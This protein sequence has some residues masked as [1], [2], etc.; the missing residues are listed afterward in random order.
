MKEAACTATPA[1]LRTLF[2]HILTFCQ[3]KDPVSLWGRIWR[4]MSEDLPYASSVSLNI[5]NLH[6]HDSQLEDYVLYELEGCLNHCSRSLTDFGLRLPPKDLMAVLRNRL[7]IEEKSYNRELLAK[8]KDTLLRK[9]NDK[10]R[11][12]FDLIINASTNNRQELIFVY[13]HGGTGKT[14]LWKT[15]T[16]TLRADRKIVLTVA[17]SGVASL[18]LPAGR[19]SHS[20]FKTLR[21]I[22]SKLDALFGGKTVMLGGDFRQTLPVKGGASRNEIVASSIAKSY[23]W[24]HFT[25]HILTENM[26]LTDENMDEMQKE[27]VSTFA[28]WLLDIGDGSIGIPDEYDPENTS[29]VEIPNIY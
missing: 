18:L 4:S 1:E 23:L 20:R 6:I 10:Q 22:L 12:I 13:G 3:V 28:K 24:H 21:D 5:P 7:L 17:S 8:E 19:T 27:R 11:Q 29:W 14:F 25:L 15:I 2:A 16:Y 9:L 26:R